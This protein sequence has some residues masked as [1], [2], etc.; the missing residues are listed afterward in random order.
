MLA[1]DQRK[2]CPVCLRFLSD[3]A[4]I[5]WSSQTFLEWYGSEFLCEN[6]HGLLHVFEISSSCYSE[7]RWLYLDQ[8]WAAL[9]CSQKL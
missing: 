2:R 5:G 3:P 6:G 8:S 1:T 4:R 7:Q 9:F